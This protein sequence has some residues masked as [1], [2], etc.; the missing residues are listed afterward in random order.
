M[1]FKLA[2]D[3]S[4]PE[5]RHAWRLGIIAVTSYLLAIFVLHLQSPQWVMVTAI[6]CSQANLGSTMRRSKERLVGTIVGSLLGILAEYLFSN[7]QIF[8]GVLFFVSALVALQFI[9]HSYT[10]YITLFTFAFILMMF[11]IPSLGYNV[12][13]VRIEDV[14]IGILIGTLGSFILWPDFASK[15]FASDVVLVVSDIRS[16]LRTTIQW[17]N[18]QKTLDAVMD[19]KIKSFNSNQNARSRITEIY[20]EFGLLKYPVKKYEKFIISQERL[21]YTL[22]LIIQSIRY[23]KELHPEHTALHLIIKK[24]IEIYTQ[25]SEIIHKIPNVGAKIKDKPVDFNTNLLA[26]QSESFQESDYLLL[27]TYIDKLNFELK[28]MTRAVNEMIEY[29]S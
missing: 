10:T 25:Y 29:E 13:Y 7:Y 5:I 8:L 20:Y 18:N 2:F 3:F 26:P 16:L 1:L 9:T 19:K 12:A 27:F 22:L 28:E 21:Y 17:M 4:I 14:V 6:V 11:R 23:E 15:M 24:M